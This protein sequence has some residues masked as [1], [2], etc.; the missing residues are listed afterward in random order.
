M[1][2]FGL[3]KSA[4]G[5]RGGHDHARCTSVAGVMWR[6]TAGACLHINTEG[7]GG[8]LGYSSCIWP[9]FIIRSAALESAAFH[10]SSP[11]HVVA[12]SRMR[13]GKEDLVVCPVDEKQMRPLMDG[14]DRL[15]ALQITN[16]QKT[17]QSDCI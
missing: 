11:T 16:K 5:Q 7:G 10:H 12:A 1:I 13:R 15:Q 17:T 4:P 6:V 3:V 9:L 2:C 14:R 8:R